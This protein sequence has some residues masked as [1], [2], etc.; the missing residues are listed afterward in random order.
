MTGNVSETAPL[1]LG[2]IKSIVRTFKQFMREHRFDPVV[3]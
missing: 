2:A 1:M 3:R